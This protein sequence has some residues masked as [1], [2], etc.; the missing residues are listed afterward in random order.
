M[1][2]TTTGWRQVANAMAERCRPSG[3]DLLQPLQV[4]WY[5]GVVDAEFRLPDFGRAESLAV[6]VGNTRMLWESFLDGMQRDPQLRA[7]DNPL[8]SYVVREVGAAILST[9]EPREICWA[10]E[11]TPHAVAMQRLAQVAGLAF[12]APSHLS[13]HA[14]YGPWIA[15]RAV[16]VFDLNGPSGTPREAVNPCDDCDRQCMAAFGQAVTAAGPTVRTHDALAEHWSH[17][18]AVRDACPVGRQHRYSDAQI[19]YHYT[20]DPQALRQALSRT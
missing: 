12:L 19:R 4:G 13:V 20:K 1:P 5:N 15:L 3:L 14:V 6:L 8:D 9:P 16:V 17:W 10:H 11:T 2:K 18:V 7:A